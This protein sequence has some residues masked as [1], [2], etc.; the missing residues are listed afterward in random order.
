MKTTLLDT[1]ND[2][3][4]L[5][6]LDYHE[7]ELLSNE[8]REFLIDS[9]STT[10]GHLSSNLGVIELT[11]ALHRVYNS[12]EDVFVF[13]VGHQCY[14]HKI[15]TGRKNEFHTLRKNGGLSGFPA[16]KE[17]KHD[18]F[19]AGHGSTSISAAIG[20][21]QAKKLKNEPGTVFAIIGDG[22][23]T[24]GMIYEGINNISSLNN[25]VII[26]ND[27]TMSISKN[28]GNLAHYFTKL[29][30]S[31]QYFKAKSDV[32]SAL[33]STPVIGKGMTKSI[34]SMKS[35]VRRSIYHS[36]FFEEL[37][38]QYIG[39]VNGHNLPELC[40]LFQ[41]IK[42]AQK[43]LFIHMETKKGK[44]F[45]LAEKNP[46][47]FHGVSAIN[48]RKLTDP[49]IAPG[50]SFSSVFGQALAAE[51]DK[52]KAIC[53]ITAAMKYGTGL[54]YFKKRH[55]D[56]FFDVG[57]AEQHAV[58]F[59]AGLAANGMLSV[60]AIYSTF[61]QRAYDQVI[62]DVSLQKLN[63]L[64]A[65]DR[66]GLVPADGE[67][68]QGIYDAAYLSQQYTMPVISPSNYKEL[69]FWLHKLINNFTVPRAI[70]YAR[71]KETEFLKNKETVETEFSCIRHDPSAQQA[72]VTY[73]VEIEEAVKAA[74]L[75]SERGM[76]VDVYQIMMINPLSKALISQLSS[77]HCILFAEEGIGQ[78]G[79]GEHLAL[80]IYT[81]GYRGDYI[82]VA[83][84]ENSVEH[85]E[86][87]ELRA[88]FGLDA[89]GLCNRL[90]A[91]G[92]K[93]EA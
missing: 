6:K 93:N 30:T 22:A 27:N 47:A 28:V 45:V 25:L 17:S 31:P 54:Q 86:V 56:R 12:P 13:D 92:G 69:T 84:P 19:L 72:I 49:D 66:A 76:L 60:P 5:K 91:D 21:A 63:V 82:H 1:I 55:P 57:M 51:A 11:I 3:S 44:G 16:P 89:R 74:E 2:P 23:F 65:I 81:N 34:Q 36:T 64:F 58:T 85:A 50:D 87:S 29:R 8:I 41:S 10:G 62:H 80:K 48:L 59:S 14:T 83:V 79:I 70:R 78:G 46:G 68:H 15:I 52:N 42:T 35:V 4:D 75:L 37:G 61:L 20:L 77:Y 32:K 24:G 33:K 26:L 7:L 67:T 38:L 53:A 18:W 71:G 43:P 88:M 73:G 40:N 39:P 9:V 90:L